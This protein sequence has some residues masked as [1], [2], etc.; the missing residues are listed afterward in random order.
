MNIHIRR[1]TEADLHAV[2][3]LSQELFVEEETRDPLLNMQWTFDKDGEAYFVKRVSGQEGICFV[4]EDDGNV[5]GYATGAVMPIQTWRVVQR[6]EMENLI[7]AKNYRGQRIGEQLVEAIAVWGKSLGA[8]R[9]LV[10]THAANA[11][12]I[13]FY[14]RVGFVPDA[15]QLEKA[16]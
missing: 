1:A 12:A 15:L 11:G 13:K 7:I 16:L 8:K 3:V 9:I 2:Q 4:A 14:Q 5:V 10:I 6:V